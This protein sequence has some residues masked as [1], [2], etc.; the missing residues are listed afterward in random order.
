MMEI[1]LIQ[2][3]TAYKIGLTIIVQDV[4]NMGKI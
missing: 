4:N 3:L 1:S 2:N